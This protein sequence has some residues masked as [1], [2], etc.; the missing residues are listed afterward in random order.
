MG[1]SSSKQDKSLTRAQSR[2]RPAGRYSFAQPGRKSIAEDTS[3]RML[4]GYLYTKSKANKWERRWC[5]IQPAE[6]VMLIYTIRGTL[7]GVTGG[8]LIGAVNL[9]NAH[10]FLPEVPAYDH[11]FCI[12]PQP[13]GSTILNMLAWPHKEPDVYTYVCRPRLVAIPPCSCSPTAHLHLRSCASRF[14]C[15]Q[16]SEWGEWTSSLKH[17]S[18]KGPQKDMRDSNLALEGWLQRKNTGR[19]VGSKWARRWFVL[20]PTECALFR[21]DSQADDAP[22]TGA[23]NLLRAD[24][25]Y[26]PSLSDTDLQVLPTEPISRCGVR[27]QPHQ[28]QL[29][30]QTPREAREWVRALCRITG[31]KCP[32]TARDNFKRA[33]AAVKALAKMQ[34]FGNGGAEGGGTVNKSTVA[35]IAAATTQLADKSKAQGAVAQPQVPA[36]TVAAGASA[37]ASESSS[38]NGASR[39]CATPVPA[40]RAPQAP[41]V[42]ASVASVAPVTARRTPTV[43]QPSSAGGSGRKSSSKRPVHKGVVSIASLTASGSKPPVPGGGAAATMRAAAPPRPR[44]ASPAAN[45]AGKVP[46]TPDS[47]NSSRMAR[48]LFHASSGRRLTA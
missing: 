26:A 35:S 4:S 3:E 36:V 5:V 8:T 17:F 10:L 1:G 37:A 18:V 41:A 47:D 13:L 27:W 32:I 21:F 11:M 34:K 46:T 40:A 23:F 14:R 6:A 16:K 29:R 22:I 12:R 44:L 43:K 25:K 48:S 7:R 33:V 39:A 15:E 42:V 31:T 38:N 19:K 30:A 24:V 2:K 9:H 45:G 20:D 28:L